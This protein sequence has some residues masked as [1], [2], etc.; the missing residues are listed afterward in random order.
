[1]SNIPP[2]VNLAD[3]EQEAYGQ[4]DDFAAMLGRVGQHLGSKKIGI[5]MVELEPAN[6]AWPYHLHYGQEEIFFVLEG[7]GTLRYD[8]N[9]YELSSGDVVLTPAGPNTAHQ[10]INTSKQKL[11]YLALSSKDDPEVCYYP[12]SDKIGAYA[13]ERGDREL[14]F[15]ARKEN[16]TDYWD[17]ES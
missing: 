4:G 11:R 16:A 7:H 8:G 9:H 12:D 2:I 14:T 15:L 1:V 3:V 17:R 13:G 10:I 5:T 6:K